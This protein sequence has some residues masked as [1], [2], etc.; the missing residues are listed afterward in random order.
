MSGAAWWQIFVFVAI[1]YVALSVFVVG[2]IWRYRF[3][4]FG[5][6]SHSS[7]IYESR[8]LRVGA[9]MFHLGVFLAIMGHALGILVPESLTEW[10]GISESEY[11][12]VAVTG[13]TIAVVLVVVGLGI[14]SLRRLADPRVRN[15]TSDS[16]KFLFPL[17]WLVILLGMAETVGYNLLGPGYN[18]RPT[19][20]EWYRGIFTFSPDVSGVTTAPILYQVHVSLAW[21]FIAAFPFTRLVHAW[22][23]PVW[24]LT[25]P[26]VIYR[27]RRST[28]VPVPGETRGWVTIGRR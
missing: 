2:H 11:S 28:P 17:M 15:A 25:R 14:L 24:Y 1:P 22:S 27:R 10:L 5:W 12:L 13:G 3:D 21:L 7:Q 23:A 20:A 16:D 19:I 4:R 6:T 18:Y 9:P 26:Y 8:W